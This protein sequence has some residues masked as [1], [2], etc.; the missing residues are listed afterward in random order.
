MSSLSS[1]S[2]R[3]PVLASVMAITIILF[4]VI[5][6]NYL[7]VREYPAVDPP[8]VTVTT[9]YTGAN[10]DIVESQ[11]TEPLE[12]SI[13]GIAGIRT[14]TSVSREG[15]STITVEFELGIDMEAA[16]NDVRDRVSR[17]VRRLPP[18]VDN[19]IVSKADAD[20]SPIVFLNVR[21]DLRDM[22][23]LTE[24]AITEFKE[25]FETIPGVS[26]VN[27]WGQK[28]YSMRLW[29]EPSRL[30]AYGLSPI[31]IRNAL[32][33]Q[34]VEL[35]SGRIEGASTELTVR[36]MS[37]LS[38]PEEFNNMIIRQNGDDIV[39]F[40]D[41]GLAMLGPQNERTILKR[42]GIPMVGV[43]LVP[44]PG[45]NNIAIA[46]EF[47]NRLEVIQRDLP[48]D[49][50]VA[51][52]F[53]VTEYIRA[54][55]SEVRQT[56]FIA[57]GL[58]MLIIF[59]FLRDWRTTLIPIIVIPI[60]LI[61]AFFVMFIMGFSINVLTMLG[62]VLAIGLVVDD[63]IVVMENIY[64]KIEMG[65][66]PIEAGLKGSKEIFFAVVSTTTAL[67]A[68]FLPVIF[69]EGLT[70]RLFREFGLVLA[71]AVIISSFVALSLSP[72][73]CSKI[74]KKRERESWI[75][76]ATEPFYVALN[77]GYR[78]SLGAFLK[79]RWAAFVIIL[80]TAGMIGY[81]GLN[82]QQELS[83]LE[84]RSR[85][86]IFA[87]GPEGVT[88]QYMDDYVDEVVAALQDDVPELDAIISVT[89]PG[90]GA[91][92]SVNSAFI[93]VTLKDPSERSRSQFEVADYVTDLLR[94]HSAARGFVT[95]EQSIRAQRGGLPV[96]YV[97]Q[98]P[99]FEKLREYLPRFM[100]AATDDPTFSVVD[101]DLKF[102]KPELSIDI[103]R[104]RARTLGVSI[105][106][107]AET[108]QLAFSGQRFDYFI[109]DGKQYEVIGQ[110]GRAFRNDPRDLASIYV[111]SDSGQL[112]QLD[113]LITISE[114]NNPP[115]LF[116][117]NR[118]V[119]A[120]VSA[121][122]AG[123]Y[124]LGDGI[125]AMDRIAA[126]VLDDSF[127][128][129][130][131]GT[132]RDFQESSDSLL[133]AFMLAVLLIYLILAAQFESF[134]DPF[135]ILFT[136]P[137]AIG[138]ALMSLYFFGQTINIFSQIGMIM[139]IG[140]VTKNAILIVEFANQRKEAGLSVM[141]AIQDAAAARFRPI[142]MT[143]LSTVLGVLPIA[144]ALGAGSESR[145]SMGIAII[146]GL[147][148]ASL[149]T[150][151]VIP[152]VYSYFSKE[153]GNRRINVD[154]YDLEIKPKTQ[155]EMA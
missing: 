119:S 25:R 120:T 134:R 104:E 133:Y 155:P 34:N 137:L 36:T 84:D 118:F 78:K 72:M 20:S 117:F 61:G 31:D 12:E 86:R 106:D 116:R 50:S 121:G 17:S 9:N 153:G 91:T 2:I 110:M 143:S 99:N 93:T 26:E 29:M 8:V 141:E 83:P 135:T 56:I 39:R 73:L 24:F 82:L 18:D 124:S 55:I 57:F 114:D 154:D 3:R 129:S 63:A 32:A 127:S 46:D 13:N 52:G 131:T 115:Q 35:P 140:L 7:G 5:G 47:Y 128:T 76:R 150:L 85:M 68:V 108:L 27:I 1:L 6:Y 125:N 58:V 42:D 45:A 109:M 75:H 112:I 77:N 14:M 103:N 67:V 139:L 38:T 87:T 62:L 136:V 54:S 70:G 145:V 148:F 149:L 138:G 146:G 80:A 113:N 11:I 97:I 152:A 89:S 28:R 33:S 98:A 96:Q 21:S 88:F 44:Q 53:D 30:A 144:L 74:L 122:L 4:G 37:R 43:V 147:L 65:M 64:A 101:V 41:V 60:A 132:S 69:L 130:L 51:I 94:N 126:N 79:V 107:V 81:F 59:M 92:S 66:N 10:A 111:R 71:G 105:R 142:L 16:A 90:F 15:R 102:N 48:E 100:D 19:P 123:G 95:Q 151:F 22:M 40:R 23:E 49:V